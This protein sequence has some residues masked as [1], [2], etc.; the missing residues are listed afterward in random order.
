[1]RAHTIEEESGPMSEPTTYEIIIG[2]HASERLLWPLLDDFAMDHPQPQRTR[3]TGIIRDSSH[4]HG[5]LAHLT[6]VAVEVISV[7]PADP[8]P[9]QTN[10]GNPK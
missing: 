5:V 6:S 9:T 8:S 1:M 4:L 10:E 7:T 2:G 3:L